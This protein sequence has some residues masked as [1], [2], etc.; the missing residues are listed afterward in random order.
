[1]WSLYKSFQYSLEFCC[2]TSQN[3]TGKVRCFW[4]FKINWFRNAS[5]ISWDYDN[6]SSVSSW[7]LLFIIQ[8]VSRLF[9]KKSIEFLHFLSGNACLRELETNS[10]QSFLM[11]CSILFFPDIPIKVQ[12]N[13]G[14]TKSQ[15]GKR[16]LFSGNNL[17]I[18]SFSDWK[19]QS[20]K[21]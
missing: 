3:P 16:Q 12:Q 15:V 2:R 14:A 8:L 9:I 19:L 4:L 6:I 11:N 5:S 21:F 7:K 20:W 17:P 10:L 1:M 13:L 18:S